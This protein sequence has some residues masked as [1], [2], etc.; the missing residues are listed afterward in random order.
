MRADRV[1]KAGITELAG[2]SVTGSR[3]FFACVIAGALA[4]GVA[5]RAD[6]PHIY[7][8]SG[9]RLITAAGGQSPPA[10]S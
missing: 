7:A 5:P 10:R 2:G 3:T 9:A 4:F 6:A 8:I 1:V